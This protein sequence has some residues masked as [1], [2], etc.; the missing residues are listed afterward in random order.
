MGRRQVCGAWPMHNPLT[1][2]V[3]NAPLAP[4]GPVGPCAH[5][6]KVDGF[7]H[8]PAKGCA[9]FHHLVA[10]LNPGISVAQRGVGARNIR[11]AVVATRKLDAQRLA[12]GHLQGGRGTAVAG[13]SE[14][15][16]RAAASGKLGGNGLKKHRGNH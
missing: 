1:S 2:A 5:L 16:A 15:G 9:N 13:G 12:Q 3:Q 6:A 14:R 11:A 8:I 7:P 10:R 4:S